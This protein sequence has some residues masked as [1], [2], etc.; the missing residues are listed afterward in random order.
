MSKLANLVDAPKVKN[1][2]TLPVDPANVS[3]V[4]HLRLPLRCQ[5]PKKHVL[6]VRK[7]AARR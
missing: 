3:Q 2:V 5:V 1:E 6:N 4:R 7:Q